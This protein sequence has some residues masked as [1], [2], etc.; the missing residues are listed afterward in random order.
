LKIL[1]TLKLIDVFYSE[2]LVFTNF[3]LFIHSF[4][5]FL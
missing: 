1:D 5:I 3:V 4:R 2:F